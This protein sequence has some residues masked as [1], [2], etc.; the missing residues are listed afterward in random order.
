M[1]ETRSLEPRTFAE[2]VAAYA[3]DDTKVPYTKVSVSLPAELV[4]LVRRSSEGTGLS[5]S[6]VVASALRQFAETVEQESLD[7]ALEL[8]AEENLAW[9]NAFLPF[10]AKL[11]SELEW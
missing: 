6:A 10:T 7:R 8:D 2:T 1:T 4:E 5:F 3:T 9:A 11:W